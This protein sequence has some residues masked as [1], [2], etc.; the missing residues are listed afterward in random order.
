MP[1]RRRG[2][3]LTRRFP[4]F[5]GKWYDEEVTP[6]FEKA[7]PIDWERAAPRIMEVIGIARKFAWSSTS[8]NINLPLRANDMGPTCDMVP[9]YAERQRLRDLMELPSL[10]GNGAEMYRLG[11]HELAAPL[12][13]CMALDCQ[14]CYLRNQTR[15]LLL[16]ENTV[17]TQL[18]PDPPLHQVDS[19]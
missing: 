6:V 13:N 19:D 18:Y 5:R 9:T 11:K 7:G 3:R 10:Y 8:T 1:S 17:V 12:C 4:S 16:T 2:G 14:R 15:T